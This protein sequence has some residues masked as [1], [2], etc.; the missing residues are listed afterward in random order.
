MNKVMAAP[1]ECL[2]VIQAISFQ[3]KILPGFNVMSNCLSFGQL[4]ITILANHLIPEENRISPGI[5]QGVVSFSRG[6]PHIRLC[7]RAFCLTLLMSRR[8]IGTGTAT[9]PTLIHIIS[10]GVKHRLAFLAEFVDTLFLHQLEYN[11]KVVYG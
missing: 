11:T 9:K 8:D 6:F 2:P 3:G 4:F 10:M 1:A 5:V 7:S